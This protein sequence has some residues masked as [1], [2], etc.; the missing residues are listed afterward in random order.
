MSWNNALLKLICQKN[1]GIKCFLFGMFLNIL[2][3]DGNE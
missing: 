3:L 1:Y 2:V